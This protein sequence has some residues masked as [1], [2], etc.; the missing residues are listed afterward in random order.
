MTSKIKEGGNVSPQADYFA[1]LT[2][3]EYS[4]FIHLSRYARYRDDLGRRETWEETIDRLIA[5]FDDHI[6]DNYP[7]VAEK[8]ASV[9]ED[10][11]SAIL[12]FE[13]MPSMRALMTAGDTLRKNNISAYNCLGAETLITTKEYGIIPIKNLVDKTVHIVDGNGEWVLATCKCYGKQELMCVTFGTSGG[14]SVPFKIYATPEHEWVASTGKIYKTKDLMIQDIDVAER[15]GDIR[16]KRSIMSVKF[17]ERDFVDIENIDYKEGIIHG[18]IYGDGTAQQKLVHENNIFTKKHC[19][20]F[21]I[22]LC[23]DAEDLL[24]YFNGYPICYPP[25]FNGNPVIFIS[26]PTLDLKDL[27]PENFD[28][29]DSYKIGF[30]RGWMAADGSVSKTSAITLAS[31][32]NGVDW[33]YKYG[34]RYGIVPRNTHEFP[35]DTNYGKR[36]ESLF[37]ITFDRRWMKEEDFIIDRKRKNFVPIKNNGNCTVRNVEKTDRIEDVFC[38]DVPTTHSFLLT[39]NILT[40]NCAFTA[41]DGNG[42]KEIVFEHEELDEAIRIKIANPIAFDEAMVILMHGTGVGFSVEERFVRQ[43]PKVGKK[44]NRRIYQKNNKNFPGVPKEELSDFDRDTNTIT[45]ADSREGWG[46]GLRI[47]IVE[48]YNGN[49]DVK[50]NLSNLRR[51]GERLKTFGGRASGPAPLDELFRFAV[52]TF[53]QA[54]GRRLKPL[55]C[56][57]L[58]CKVAAVVIAGSSRRSALISLSD[59]HDDELRHAKNGNWWADNQQR[60]LSNNSISYKHRPD[61][62]SFLREWKALIESKSGER[63]IYNLS[64]VRDHA[65]KIGKRNP[66][67]IDGS[68]PCAEISLRNKQ[69]CNL[70][71]LIVRPTDDNESLKRKVELATILGTLQATLTN[72][73]YISEVWKQNCEEERLL[74]V[75]MS[76][77]LDNPLTAGAD[78]PQTQALLLWLRQHT[79]DVNQDWSKALGINRSAAITTVKP[80]GTASQLT[81][82]ASG[83]HPRYA[84]HYIRTVRIDKKDVIYKFMVDK[85]FPVE[86]DVTNPGHTGVFSFPIKAPEHAVLRTDLTA[87]QQ[88]ALWRLY[89]KYW[90]EHQPSITVYVKDAEWLEV[91]AWVYQNFNDVRGISFLPY[92]D[93]IYRQAPYQEITEEEYKILNKKM[94]KGI[95]WTELAAYEQEDNTVGGHSLSCTGGSCEIVDL[96]K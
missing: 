27:P 19:T 60:A 59:A 18:L 20:G 73:K 79:N 87:L 93:H 47:L 46:S 40:K 9:R 22:R 65:K 76:G 38:F 84:R 11:R 16:K 2:T 82:S 42:G 58:M 94:P 8:Y 63:G 5:F 13:I 83:I 17:P 50:W 15:Y 28:L 81:D 69:F 52:K 95:D 56:H 72:F 6:R 26:R 24:K 85:K 12:N 75:S 62:D 54:N 39:K 57:D 70:S 74:G 78:L 31:T 43:L 7:K 66:D 67:L 23:C 92:A 55:E 96:T 32:K 53:K 49:F 33:I 51:A 77:I 37:C 21:S 41:I 88:L 10:L 61:M 3:P 68:N 71:S 29:S 91:G 25:T 48:L 90:C 89:A 45:V 86:D 64:G 36:T 44:M 14:N 34:P 4:R 80:E 35:K 1:Q 30:I